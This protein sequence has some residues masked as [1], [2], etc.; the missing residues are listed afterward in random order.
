MNDD[1]C[2]GVTAN[3]RTTPLDLRQQQAC[4]WCFPRVARLQRRS[5][6]LLPLS[7]LSVSPSRSSMLVLPSATSH[8]SIAFRSSSFPLHYTHLS[9]LYPFIQQPKARAAL[10]LWRIGK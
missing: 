8:Y 4:C 1:G 6:P 3:D 9:V 5:T 2:V 7:S 10:S